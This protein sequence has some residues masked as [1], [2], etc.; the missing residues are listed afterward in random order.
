MKFRKNRPDNLIFSEFPR[1][2]P[3]SMFSQ[4][5]NIFCKSLNKFKLCFASVL[6]IFLQKS[7]E[8][9]CHHNFHKN[10]PVVSGVA[11]KFCLSGFRKKLSPRFPFQL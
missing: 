5:E 7:A 6:Q 8:V 9:S 10:G 11:E 4:K 2:S 1:K 3:D